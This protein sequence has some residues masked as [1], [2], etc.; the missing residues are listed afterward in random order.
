MLAVQLRLIWLDDI[1]VA[2]SPLGAVG[3]ACRTLVESISIPLTS[4]LFTT[5]VNT[6]TNCPL[7]FAGSVNCWMLAM[8][9]PPAAAKMSKFVSTCVPLML[10]LNVARP[11]GR[12]VGL[13]EVQP[14]HIVR[15]GR[16]AP[17]GVGEVAV[18]AGLVDGRGR[19]VGHVAGV[20]RVGVTDRAAAGEVLVGHERAHRRGRPASMAMSCVPPPP[21]DCVVALAW[22]EGADVPAE[23]VPSTR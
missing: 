4:E 3:A 5:D 22:F 21:L 23:S 20:D 14:H 13:A 1:A 2:P 15:P 11:G 17:D 6:I 12:E 8:F 7:E 19:R 18:A 10:T 16:E 9:C